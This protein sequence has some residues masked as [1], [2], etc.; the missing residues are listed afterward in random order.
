PKIYQLL[1]SAQDGLTY[2]LERP[3][4]LLLLLALAGLVV[5]AVAGWRMLPAAWAAGFRAHAPVYALLMFWMVAAYVGFHLLMPAASY[6]LERL[7]LVLWTPF[8]LC[9]SLLASDVLRVLPVRAAVPAALALSLLF[10]LA[11]GRFAPAEDTWISS[12]RAMI[13][14]LLEALGRRN[15]PPGTRFYATPNEHLTLTYYSGLPIQSVAPVRREFFDMY[16]GRIVFIEI[17]LDGMFPR[18][19]LLKAIADL[20]R[21]PHNP[22]VFT[23]LSLPV[24]EHLVRRELIRRGFAIEAPPP[25]GIIEP[26]TRKTLTEFGERRA[27]WIA[28]MRRNPIFRH[29]PAETVNDLWLGFFYRFVE[30]EKRIGPNLNILR[31]LRNASIELVPLGRSVIFT[32]DSPP[33][34]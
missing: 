9:V 12:D 6:F 23:N 17:Q 14:A 18:E 32:S 28:D 25:E 1:D 7:S 10:L 11:R 8:V 21:W 26:L 2:L 4:P 13:A 3:V 27:D 30:P 20:N 24:W 22:E 16:P 34:P 19:D 31:R 15:D 29:V 5:L 33:G